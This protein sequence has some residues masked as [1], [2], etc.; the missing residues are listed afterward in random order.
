MEWLSSWQYFSNTS[1]DCVFPC[2]LLSQVWFTMWTV[3][4]S[5]HSVIVHLGRL[6]HC[7]PE[8]SR[9]LPAAGGR[10]R[11]AGN[12]VAGHRGRWS[13][14]F[15]LS[16]RCINVKLSVVRQRFGFLWN[17][18]DA[19]LGYA[20]VLQW[21]WPQ[22]RRMVTATAKLGTDSICNLWHPCIIC[23]WFTSVNMHCIYSLGLLGS[24][25][26]TFYKT[27]KKKFLFKE[28]KLHQTKL[29]YITFRGFD[30]IQSNAMTG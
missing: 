27:T 26:N 11:Q 30:H 17:H 16:H 5:G 21:L 20:R 9:Q 7:C 15:H 1:F 12:P 14:I 28:K 13:H 25:M 24:T 3:W 2:G 29:R 18:W 19:D 10:R 8:K 6:Q 22:N 4:A 23:T